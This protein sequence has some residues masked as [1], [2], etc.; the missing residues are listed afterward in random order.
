VSLTAPP[1]GSPKP[2]IDVPLEAL[3]PPI[4]GPSALGTDRR[5][6]WRLAWVLAIT[7]FKLKFFG[8]VLGYLWQ[9]M[10]PLLLF[11]VLFVVFTLIVNL[12]GQVVFFATALLLG[13]VLYG[14]FSEATAGAVRAVVDRE[15]L[16]RKVEFPR[17]AIPLAVVITA[18]M[19]LGLNLVAVFVFLFI[20]GG[21][22]LLSWLELPL[23]IG[24]LTVLVLGIGMLLSASY[25]RYRDVAPIWEVILQALFYGSAI[26]YPVQTIHGAHAHLI[27]RLLMLNPFAAA[28]QQ[29]RHAIIDPSHPSAAVAI[30][31]APWL[32]IPAGVTVVLFVWGYWVFRRAAPRI[33]E[34]L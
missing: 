27:V 33:A 13:I 26:F 19:N 29:A 10:R 16:V 14:F 1:A 25:V 8:S 32:L 5:R 15:N 34:L 4:A 12:R 18:L 2:L 24:F 23:I 20:Q 31:G 6:L 21:T 3:G 22:P 30:G 7:D 9:L 17:L 11:G 28:L